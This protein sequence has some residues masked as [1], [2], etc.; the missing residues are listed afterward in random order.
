MKRIVKKSN[1][2][3]V[4]EVKNVTKTYVLRHEKPTLIENIFRKTK[5]ETHFA[6]K[7]IS[8]SISKGDRLGIIGSN[9]SGKTTILKLLAGITK[10]QKGSIKI[11]G[12]IVSL[13]DL[14]A[15]FHPD[16]TGEENIFLNGIIIGMTKKEIEKKKQSILEFANIGKFIDAPL[17]TYSSGMQLRLGFSIAVHSDPDILLIDEGFAVGDENFREKANQK[18]FEFKKNGKTLVMV[19]H[20]LQE[21]DR[22]CD[23]V[24][25]IEKGSI[26]KFGGKEILTQ[27]KEYNSKQEK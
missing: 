19:S 12:K 13:I 27:Y 18:I 6:L 25:W 10:Q 16:L 8:F 23:K 14:S 15:G 3:L 20:W 7:N 1:K 2:K 22:N 5:N 26:V 21:I 24:L 17:Y 9:G 11:K 4:V